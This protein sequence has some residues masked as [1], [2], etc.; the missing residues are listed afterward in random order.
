MLLASLHAR[1]ARALRT[2]DG[3]TVA[4]WQWIR[5][6]V[7]PWVE[8]LPFCLMGCGFVVFPSLA[9]DPA[10]IELVCVVC[11]VV[12]EEEKGKEFIFLHSQDSKPIEDKTLEQKEVHFPRYKCPTCGQKYPTKEEKKDCLKSHYP[13]KPGDADGE[14]DTDADAD[15]YGHG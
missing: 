1:C 14:D 7:D 4:P 6:G 10:R 12:Q 5:G 15:D 11:A 2:V 3:V 9:A 13:K 8:V